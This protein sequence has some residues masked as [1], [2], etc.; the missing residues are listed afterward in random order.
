MCIID[1]LKYKEMWKI[2]NTTTILI[3]L[4]NA[5]CSDKTC[6]KLLIMLPFKHFHIYPLKMKRLNNIF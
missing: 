2:P 4:M 3:W 1:T 5:R 6:S